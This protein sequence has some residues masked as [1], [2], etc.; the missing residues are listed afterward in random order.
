MLWELFADG[1]V[2]DWYCITDAL[3]LLF[4]VTKA[5]EG[6]TLR[7]PQIA[8]QLMCVQIFYANVQVIKLI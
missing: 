7:I 3:P 4:F 2:E 6:S 5:V 8:W 1:F